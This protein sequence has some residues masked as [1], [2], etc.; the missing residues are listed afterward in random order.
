MI[1]STAK[2]GG[3]A[4]GGPSF[5]LWERISSHAAWLCERR[6]HGAGRHR[7]AAGRGGAGNAYGGGGCSHPGVRIVNLRVAGPSWS[8]SAL[9]PAES[10]PRHPRFD[11]NGRRSC[12]SIR[13]LTWQ[14][15]LRGPCRARIFRPLRRSAHHQ[16]GV[17]VWRLRVPGPD[18]ERRHCAR[19][20]GARRADR[21]SCW[22]RRGRGS[23]GLLSKCL[24]KRPGC[25]PGRRK[26]RALRRRPPLGAFA[27]RRTCAGRSRS[28]TGLFDPGRPRSGDCGRKRAHAALSGS[29][30][31]RPPQR[32]RSR[33]ERGRDPR[34]RSGWRTAPDRAY[35]RRH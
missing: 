15:A 18:F 11:Q 1:A 23:C 21:H 10:R 28:R 3:G 17:P 16:S 5:D 8:G 2:S 25:M 31:V 34:A 14:S 30:Y 9:G 33:P 24:A 6:R 32:V 4:G 29:R 19:P 20:S 27:S 7:T 22:A 12:S 35:R 26:D 13:Q